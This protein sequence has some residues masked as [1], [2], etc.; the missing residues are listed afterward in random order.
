MRALLGIAILLIVIWIIARV[1]GFLAGAL[2][3][4]LWI[5]A[6]V[7]FVIWL[8]GLITG[9]NRSTGTRAP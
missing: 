4:L 3:N 1:V 8:I 6:L 7:L 2:L 5:I 9:R